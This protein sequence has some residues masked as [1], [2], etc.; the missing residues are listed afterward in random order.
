MDFRPLGRT[1][2][3]VSSIVLGCG[4]FGGVGPPRHLIGRGLDRDAAWASMNEAVALGINV[5]D[6]AASY[7]G[8]ASERWISEWL[9][10]QT[11]ETL[12]NI[13]IATKV[14]TVVSDTGM[15]LDLSPQNI[16]RQLVTSL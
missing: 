16:S 3:A 2:I 9:R 14:G 10:A 15:S 4:N 8:A 13:R 7:A 11:K 5:F 6:T 12:A 1:G